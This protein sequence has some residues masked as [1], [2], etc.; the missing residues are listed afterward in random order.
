MGD[1]LRTGKSSWYVTSHPGQLSLAIPPWIG[2][3]STNESWAV[4]RHTVR[5][6]S[7]VSVVSQRALVSGWGPR[8]RRSAPPYGPCGSGRTLL[9]LFYCNISCTAV[10]YIFFSYESVQRENCV[11]GTDEAQS[12]PPSPMLLLVTSDG[13]LLCY[14]M[15]L[16]LPNTASLNIQPELLQAAERPCMY[17]KCLPVPFSLVNTIVRNILTATA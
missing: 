5:Y 10:I 14:Y 17:L 8:K 4:S 6:T 15:M 12:H 9:L 7:P 3:V 13:L 1:R 2:A 16:S 11:F